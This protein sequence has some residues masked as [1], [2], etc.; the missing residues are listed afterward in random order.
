MGRQIITAC[1]QCQATVERETWIIERQYPLGDNR[2]PRTAYF[3]SSGCLRAYVDEKIP[4]PVAQDAPR[5]A[6]SGPVDS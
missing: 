1:D 2:Y 5:I 3:C 6:P 4:K